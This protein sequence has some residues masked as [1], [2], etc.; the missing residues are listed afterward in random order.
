MEPKEDYLLVRSRRK[1]DM[2]FD[3]LLVSHFSFHGFVSLIN[4]FYKFYAIHIGTNYVL[5]PYEL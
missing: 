1:D 4:H 5:L 2:T 3:Y